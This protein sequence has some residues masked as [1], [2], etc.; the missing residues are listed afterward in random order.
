MSAVVE[1]I[2]KILYSTADE[3]AAAQESAVCA[4]GEPAAAVAG[5]TA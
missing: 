4:A 3:P 2:Q 5:I 1:E